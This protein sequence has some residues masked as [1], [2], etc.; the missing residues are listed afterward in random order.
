MDSV[1]SRPP[2]KAVDRCS[3]CGDTAQYHPLMYQV[4]PG[5]VSMNA[6]V[7]TRLH[8]HCWWAFTNHVRRFF[9]LPPVTPRM[10]TERGGSHG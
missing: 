6:L 2:R 4:P 10:T 9:D 7:E 1:T 5:F 3:Y 8:E